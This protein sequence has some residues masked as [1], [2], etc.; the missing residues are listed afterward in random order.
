MPRIHIAKDYTRTPGPRYKKLGKYSGQD[1]RERFLVP[2]LKKGGDEPIEIVLDG[3]A[4]YPVSFI[5]EAFAGL[6]Y[7][8]GLA[9]EMIKKRLRFIANDPGYE[10][11]KILAERLIG[12][13][14]ER[15]ASPPPAKAAI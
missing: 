14:A 4:G 10:V 5:D 6:I 3:T 8:E 7:A 12:E 11:Y 15:A 1:F 2:E 9:P 13:A